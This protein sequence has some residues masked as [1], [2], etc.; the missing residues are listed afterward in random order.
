MACLLFNT[1]LI[2]TVLK[3]KNTAMSSMSHSLDD[4]FYNITNIG[5]PSML[6][7]KGLSVIDT[8]D[9]TPYKVDSS[10]IPGL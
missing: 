3:T 5:Q 10:E 1:Y 8:H 7:I 9:F 4:K 6:F 2:R